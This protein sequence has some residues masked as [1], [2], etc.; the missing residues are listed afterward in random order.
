MKKLQFLVI[1]SVFVM[2]TS[3]AFAA[4]YGEGGCGLGSLIFG[5]DSGV[6]QIFAS[7]TNGTSGNQTFGITSGTSNCD[8]K[9]IVLAKKE[10]EIFLGYNYESLLK[11]MAIGKGENLNT[12]AG[13]MGCS[14]ESYKK[15]GSFAKKNYSS[16][17]K[18]GDTASDK[19]LSVI[20]K[21]LSKDQ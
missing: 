19:M 9:G 8:S 1:L 12:L 4:G 13:L 3:S 7:T 10:Q 2:S 11:E 21:E 16:I 17:V 6:V 5:D 18:T 20:K 14:P 15:F